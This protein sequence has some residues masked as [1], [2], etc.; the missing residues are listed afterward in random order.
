MF[1]RCSLARTA[2]R[3][4]T[5]C[6]A[7]CAALSACA[8]A[9]VRPGIAT[10]D[11]GEIKSQLLAQ[12]SLVAQQQRR[13]DELEMKVAAM[14]TRRDPAPQ[15]TPAPSP[16]FPARLE[17]RPQLKTVKLGEA[18]APRPAARSAVP[19]RAEEPT[20][21]PRI[22]N[23]VE[24]APRLPSSVELKEPDGDALAR[25]EVDP[26]A[27]QEGSADFAWASAIR[28]LNE[29]EHAEAEVELL[30][31]AAKNP[32]HA[33]ADN[34]LYLAGLVREA[35]GDCEHALPLFES[36]P[37]KYPAGDAVPQALLE[38]GRCLGILG[39]TAEAKKILFQL[40]QEHPDAPESA[41]GKQLSQGL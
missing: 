26:A 3:C 34:A 37:G 16:V 7:L 5:L 41:Q 23:P 2:A 17:V 21:R 28:K 35:R 4:G 11:L 12:S 33:A 9:P 38:R 20:R 40:E 14:A 32:R 30:A 25:L 31:F 19:A 1:L 22:E 18:R 36:V 8:S 6:A 39:K 29:G 27:A 15:A 10:D 24:R 13:I